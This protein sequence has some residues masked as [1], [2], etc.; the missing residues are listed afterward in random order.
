MSF[1]YQLQSLCDAGVAH[2]LASL[3]LTR[4]LGLHTLPAPVTPGTALEAY[5]ATGN[6]ERHDLRSKMR[7]SQL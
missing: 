2:A 4:A 1:F 7:R 6:F 3:T 5:H